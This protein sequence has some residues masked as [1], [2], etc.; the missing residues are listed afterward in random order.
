MYFFHAVLDE[1]I[2]VE[3]VNTLV[4]QYCASG[5]TVDYYQDPA[6]DHNSLAVSGA[7]A[8]VANLAARFAGNAPTN[9]CGL[10]ILP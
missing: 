5:V 8:A 9:T 2:P 1:L 4:A 7:P 10:P 3:D 6:S